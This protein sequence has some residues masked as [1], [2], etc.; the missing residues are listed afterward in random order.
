MGIIVWVILALLILLH[1]A[2]LRDPS[3][4]GLY[5]FEIAI[6][7]MLPSY[8]YIIVR[9]TLRQKYERD[10]ASRRFTR[11]VEVEELKND[12][13]SVAQHQLRTPLSGIRFALETLRSEPGMP[14]DDQGLVDSGIERVGDASRS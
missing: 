10:E 7:S 9:E 11:L 8:M 3:A 14:A 12:F 6:F 2:D 13:L 5:L 1:P 4:I